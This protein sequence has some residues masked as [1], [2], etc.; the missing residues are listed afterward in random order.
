MSQETSTPE[1]RQSAAE[2]LA[3]VNDLRDAGLSFL[4]ST[5]VLSVLSTS[6]ATTPAWCRPRESVTDGTKKVSDDRTLIRYLLRHRHT[7]PFEMAEIKF[8][9]RVPMDCWRQWV[10][11]LNC[12]I[13]E[14]TARGIRWRSK[15]LR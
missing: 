4:C 2:R 12:H 6:W 5:M 7:T 3:Q 9:V 14:Y 13:N 10:R 15:R 8:L 11:H 1:S